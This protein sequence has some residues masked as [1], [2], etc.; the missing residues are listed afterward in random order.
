MKLSRAL[1]NHKFSST[2][3]NATY[4]TQSRGKVILGLVHPGKSDKNTSLRETVPLLEFSWF[5]FAVLVPRSPPSSCPSSLVPRARSV[6]AFPAGLLPSAELAERTETTSYYLVPGCRFWV[7]KQKW[8]TNR[9][10]D[11]RRIRQRYD[12]RHRR[13]NSFTRHPTRIINIRQTH[14]YD[15]L[16]NQ[17]KFSPHHAQGVHILCKCLRCQTTPKSLQWI[18]RSALTSCD[19]VISEIS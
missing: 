18:S 2:W 6:R 15:G 8:V 10:A 3:R 1:G 11:D 14:Y 16:F 4:N 5:L 19:F 13:S 12:A 7:S 9:A 17:R